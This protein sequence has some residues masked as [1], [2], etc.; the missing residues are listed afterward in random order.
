MCNG[1]TENGEFYLYVTMDTSEHPH[2]AEYLSE[3]VG[4]LIK[5]CANEY[6][7]TVTSFI[8]DNAANMNKMEKEMKKND[9]DIDFITFGYS[10][11][12]MNLLTRDLEFSEIKIVQL[13]KYFKNNHQT[14]AKYK[15]DGCRAFV[16]PSDV[17]W[18]TMADCLKVYIKKWPKLIKICEE[19]TNNIDS[20]IYSKI[21]HI[22]IKQVAMK[23]LK[24]QI[25]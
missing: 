10:A 5:S 15:Q 18:N 9:D 25:L 24:I 2:N 19:N 23:Y 7:C 12:L 21:M 4:N 14:N 16:L 22:F 13:I 3:I 17:S 11:H 1:Y 8:T 6:N 20:I